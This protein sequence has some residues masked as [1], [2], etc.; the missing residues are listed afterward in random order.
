MASGATS[1]A[2]RPR[3]WS[4]RSELPNPPSNGLDVARVDA[5][6]VSYVDRG[7]GS[8]SADGTAVDDHDPEPR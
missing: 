8:A 3:R 5:Q 6:G 7:C 4:A 2:P 1:P